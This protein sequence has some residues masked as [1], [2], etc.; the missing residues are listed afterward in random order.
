M[1]YGKLVLAA[2]AVAACNLSYATAVSLKSSV[3]GGG[4]YAWGDDI[5]NPS[6]PTS[7]DDVTLGINV[8]KTVNLLAGGD[9]YE[10]N[11]L[12]V[13]GPLLVMTNAT[14]RSAGA[15]SI[16]TGSASAGYGPDRLNCATFSN[17]TFATGVTG[18]GGAL[19][20][21]PS[22]SSGI[23]N[24]ARFANCTFCYTNA[25][26][27]AGGWYAGKS[28]CIALFEGCDIVFSAL[29]AYRGGD[30]TFR[31]CTMNKKTSTSDYVGGADASLTSRMVFDGC[32]TTGGLKFSMYPDS[33][34][35]ELLVSGGTHVWESVAAG[36]NGIVSTFVV[37]NGARMTVTGGNG[38][39]FGSKPSSGAGGLATV[40]LDSG[41]I[42]LTHEN[43]TFILGNS[44]GSRASMVVR[45]GMSLSGAS[46]SA[47]SSGFCDVTLEGA[48]LS[49]GEFKLGQYD[50]VNTD[51]ASTVRQ[52][53]G[54]VRASQ[55]IGLSYN[56]Q[57]ASAVHATRYEATDGAVIE[58]AS[59]FGGKK[60]SD[61][62]LCDLASFYA[63]GATLR[64]IDRGT[65]TPDYLM[66][67]I[68]S[69]TVGQRGLVVDTAGHAAT[70]LQPVADAT[71]VHGR[72][73]KTGTGTLTVKAPSWTVS[74]TVAAG[75]T[76]K[77]V[78]DSGTEVS[79][80]TGVV[81]TNG[82]TLSL[83]G[84]CTRLT[85][86][87]L[88][89]SNATIYVD[90]GD[91]I[92]VSGAMALSNITINYYPIPS[93]GSTNTILVCDG[94]LSAENVRALNQAIQK[95]QVSSLAHRRVI[96]ERD[97]LT[98]KTSVR[99]ATTAKANPLS[100][101]TTWKGDTAAAWN[102]ADNG[103]TD[104]V[105]DE[106]TEAVFPAGGTASRSVTA[107]AGAPVGA[108]RFSDGYVLCG[109]SLE[110]LVPWGAARIVTEGG[111]TEVSAPI[112]LYDTLI[113]TN[114]AGT[115]LTLSGG[116][117]DGG[118][119]KTGKG[120]LVLAGDNVFWRDV[121]LL[122]GITEIAN[123]G[124][125]HADDGFDVAIRLGANTLR[126]DNPLGEKTVVG[127]GLAISTEGAKQLAVVD[128]VTDAEIG[129]VMCTKGGFIKSGAGELVV[130]VADDV[131]LQPNMVSKNW[132]AST[133]YEPDPDGTGP[134]NSLAPVASESYATGV[135]VMEGTLV[136]RKSG[137]AG[138][139]VVSARG[140]ATSVGVHTTNTAIRPK[141]VFDGVVYDAGNMRLFANGF[142]RGNDYKSATEK[143]AIPP[144]TLKG[145]FC[146]LNGASL[147]CGYFYQ[148]TYGYM[149]D[150]RPLVS[151]T[152]ATISA[153]SEMWFADARSA[154]T[155]VSLQAVSAYR[156]KDSTLAAGK[157]CQNG[158][159]DGDFVNSFVGQV[160]EGGY[161]S[162][163]FDRAAF[164][165]LLFRDGSVFRVDAF[166]YS[167][168]DTK[169]SLTF[170]FDDAEW[171]Y[172]TTNY[173]FAGVSGAMADYLRFEMRGKGV[174][175]CPPADTTFTAA[176]P[177]T[178][179]G[180][181]QAAG[182][183]TV[184]FAAGTALF[185]GGLA[186]LSGT[187]DMSEAGTT[188]ADRTISGAGTLK[189][190]S[191]SA[192][193]IAVPFDVESGSAG[194]VPTLDGCSIAGRI[195]I[196]IGHSRENP[197]PDGTFG[198]I[199]VARFSGAVPAQSS[200]RLVGTGRTGMHGVFEVVGSE[201]RMTVENTGLYIIY[202]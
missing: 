153:S 29:R 132:Y 35:S 63:D 28:P 98:G 76:L 139:P 14:L 90:P 11:T 141:L 148:N 25:T 43:G 46:F 24:H 166:D 79:W 1:N 66:Y 199:T 128:A 68:G 168:F 45:S 124:A 200:W 149:A 86:E 106:R 74:E 145:E 88:T 3:M 170:A 95:I 59:I 201:V 114:A 58:T 167:G 194:P 62:T 157:F 188:L 119:E 85:V 172:G 87:S 55:F 19:S 15:I 78:A 37:T 9:D 185:G 100:A 174:K 159:V 163:K 173:T 161:G 7:A 184:K 47:G 34:V 16:K 42:E 120:K 73:V 182:E 21:V 50:A 123:V 143:W 138:T 44:L 121:S 54:T 12:T 92:A 82:A 72:I 101:T 140:D 135:T 136:F 144:E 39:R 181:V 8:N 179:D 197:I 97:S 4:T 80:N 108:M 186:V 146:M 18:D 176:F 107:P 40:E 49:F 103:W 133:I 115:S 10:F 196:D 189:G 6:A 36:Q 193:T 178:G 180:G 53:G 127:A 130:N 202:R 105:P 13:S 152:N 198:P 26:I 125:L 61:G 81:V 56:S 175:L 31:N 83:F 150:M 162:F 93:S 155:S 190:A 191:L 91:V 131:D 195:K 137:G 65:L 20:M 30:M 69:A 187:L 183:G 129:P 48:T 147:L 169:Y 94:E 160:G 192:P 109:G 57:N 142:N 71:G 118:L 52:K 158:G 2:I 126:F 151:M 113:V 112:S 22:S 70:I 60:T 27:V 96:I 41:S 171:R 51:T 165:V 111:D 77:S 117:S 67:G 134:D 32:T 99:I 64:V 75:G 122:G 110:M 116:L 102:D 23:T 84:D 33:S 164:G 5:W 104:G 38:M 154:K 89:V 156:V 17:V 177:F